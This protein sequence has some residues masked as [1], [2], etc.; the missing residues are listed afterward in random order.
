MIIL[1]KTR[2]KVKKQV[3]IFL[4]GIILLGII[5]YAGTNIYQ[6]AQYKKTNEYKLIQVGYTKDEAKLLEDNLSKDM[7][8]DL[9]NSKKDTFVLNLLKEKYY[10]KNN[11]DRYQKFHETH[12]DLDASKVI[13]LVNTNNDYDYYNHDLETDISKDYLLLVNKYYHLNEDYEPDDLVNVNNKYYYGENHKVRSVLYEAFKDMW[14]EAYKEN[15]YLIMNSTYR[16]FAS[17]K[18]VYDDYKDRNGTTYADSIAARAGYSEHQTGLAIDIFSKENTTTSSFKGSTAH[19]WLQNNAYKFGF[20]ERYQEDKVDIT[21][22]AAEAWHWRYVG[23]EAA[24]YI[25]ENN[26]TFDEY[27][28]YFIEK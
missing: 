26:I 18:E 9:I 12:Q 23:V 19:L 11:L 22:F 16:S 1:K 6:T 25:H 20:I 5:I 17:Q 15:I 24:T 4:A 27:Y 13:S 21:G 14:E 3:W 10:L 2:L 7:L 28:A 8:N